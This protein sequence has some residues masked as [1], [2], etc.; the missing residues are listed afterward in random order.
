MKAAHCDECKW[1]A[2]MNENKHTPE[3]WRV[4]LGSGTD[5][6]NAADEIIAYGCSKDVARRIVACVN[7]CKRFPIE[8]LEAAAAC[9]GM[10]HEPVEEL[11]V[12]RKQRDVLLDAVTRCYKML[13]SEPDTQGALF[14]AENILREAIADTN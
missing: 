3:P 1:F 5:V 9:G 8:V 12:V 2:K 11:L 6:I 10:V 14:K 4:D 13:L 7:A